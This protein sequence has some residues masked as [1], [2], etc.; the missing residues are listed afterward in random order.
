MLCPFCETTLK[1]TSALH[2]HK[3]FVHFW[4]NFSCLQCDQKFNFAEEVTKHM[5]DRDELHEH[6][7][8]GSQFIGRPQM[9]VE[10]QLHF[11]LHF[12]GV[13]M[14]FET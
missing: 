11:K 8:S 13:K 1:S 4:G 7:S 2:Y 9:F 14:K 6:R 5:E 12:L 3:K 10:F